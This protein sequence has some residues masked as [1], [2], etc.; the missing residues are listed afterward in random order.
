MLFALFSWSGRLGRLAYFGYSILLVTVLLVLGLVLLLPLRNASDGTGVGIAIAV[1]LV[2]MAIWGGFCLVAKRL[3]DLD[4]SAWHYAWIIL[5]PAL[6][7]GSGTVLK[8]SGMTLPGL[9]TSLL[10]AVISLLVGVFLLFW[11]G[12]DGTN[13]FGERP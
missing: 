12:T 9:L 5:V 10:G 11:P 8:Q 6:C 1:I 4:V 7:D 2:L 3:H 13:R